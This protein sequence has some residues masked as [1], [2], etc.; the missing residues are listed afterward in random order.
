MKIL[1]TLFSLFDRNE[2]QNLILLFFFMFNNALVQVFGIAIIAPLIAAITMPD[3]LESSGYITYITAFFQFQTHQDFSIAAGLLILAIMLFG[4]SFILATNY[5]SLR[6][7]NNRERSIGCRLLK[8]YLQQPFVFFLNRHSAELLRNVHNEV[9]YIASNVVVKILNLMTFSITAICIIVFILIINPV[10]TLILMSILGGAYAFIYL[11]IKKPLYLLGR[12]SVDLTESKL[13]SITDSIRMIKEI[14]MQNLEGM[15]LDRFS[16]AARQY[17]RV[18]TF[19][20]TA[21]MAPKYLIEIFGS[22]LLFVPSYLWFQRE[23]I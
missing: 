21:G 18:R 22:P 6:Y 17:A 15:F 23:K 3:S 4:N 16:K 14:K 13:R 5:L 7:A 10:V 12:Q 8:M 1:R 9:A 11:F 20:D 2:K 19:S